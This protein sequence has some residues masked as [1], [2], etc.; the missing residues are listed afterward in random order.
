MKYI[1]VSKTESHG[2]QSIGIEILVAHDRALTENECYDIQQKSKEIQEIILEKTISL[3]PKAIASA[4]AERAQ[5]VGLFSEPI[6]VEEIPNGYCSQYCCKHLPWFV[7]TT[8]VGRIKIGWRKRVINIDWSETT[9]K[10]PGGVLFPTEEST[11]GEK[12]ENNPYYI[13]AWTIDK[14]KEYIECILLNPDTK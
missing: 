8:K 10:I 3:D 2:S 1:S 5:L 4:A 13:H 7:V 6:F 11:K 9:C 14:A 12:G